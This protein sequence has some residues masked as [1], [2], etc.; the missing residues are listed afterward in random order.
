M[1]WCIVDFCKYS[2]CFVIDIDECTTNTHNCDPD[3]SCANS[4]GS[5]V[6]TCN[7][8]YSGDG[9][10]CSGENLSD[11]VQ[12]FFLKD[13]GADYLPPCDLQSV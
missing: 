7:Q 4:I 2:V 1:A 9:I 8:G 5:F 6:C 13:Q 11:S 3:A 12:C 10:T